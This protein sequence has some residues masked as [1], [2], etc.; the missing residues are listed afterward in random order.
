MATIT[1]PLDEAV[2]F[3][4]RATRRCGPASPS[5][6]RGTTRSCSRASFHETIEPVLAREGVCARAREPGRRAARRLADPLGD[7]PACAACGELCKRARCRTAPLVYVGDGYSDRCAALAADRVFARA[8]PRALPRLATAC[9]SSRSRRSTTLL[10]RFPEPYDFALSTERFRAFGVDLANLWH[11][12]GLH[13]VVGGREVRIE[14][15]PGG[16]DVEPLD[17]ETAPVVEKLLGRRVRARAVPR[18]GGAAAGARRARAAARRLPA[19]ARA[20]PV[21]EPRHLD[22]RAAGVA[23][24][25]VRDPQPADRALRRAGRRRV[26]LPDA[27]ADRGGARGRAR[28]ASASRGARPSTCVGLARA[29]LDL[30]AL[31][32]L[33][34]R[35]GARAAHGAARARALDGRMVPRA[36]PRPAAR[37]AGRRPRA[38]QGGRL[39]YGLDVHELGPRLDPFQNLSAHYLLTGLRAP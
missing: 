34:R 21:R 13:R 36:A 8:R 22:H 6:P 3:P 12:G 31:A 14:A 29:E 25:R 16:V 18:L 30:D 5:S 1:A 32:L 15:A 26:R 19:A 2:A 10:L 17:A 11:E 20:R 24:R 28:R 4:R 38:A 27:R 23:L 35:R 7:G 9:R 39:F 37:V 33:A